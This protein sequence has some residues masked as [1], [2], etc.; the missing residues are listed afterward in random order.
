MDQ[1]SQEDHIKRDIHCM[2]CIL[3]YIHSY[4]Q[5]S[6]NPYLLTK[7]IFNYEYK[8][9]EWA[10]IIVINLYTL[11]CSSNFASAITKSI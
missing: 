11:F 6:I 2:C 3:S 5:T 8:F 10:V 7:Y 1:Y 4:L 9:N